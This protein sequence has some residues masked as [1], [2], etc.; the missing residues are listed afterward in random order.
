[1]WKMWNMKI[2][3]KTRG[4]YPER[5]SRCTRVAW[6]L[7]PVLLSLYPETGVV[8]MDSLALEWNLECLELRKMKGQNGFQ[9]K[10]LIKTQYLESAQFDDQLRAPIPGEGGELVQTEPEL[11]ARVPEASL[12]LRHL[13]REVVSWVAVLPAPLEHHPLSTV[14]L[15]ATVWIEK[16]A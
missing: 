16:H 15:R 2:T 3:A 4:H 7:Q 13:P 6:H 12:V 14:E 5:I 10:I 9:F 8:G 11:G 1:M